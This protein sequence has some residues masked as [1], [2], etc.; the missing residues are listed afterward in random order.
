MR[1]LISVVF[2]TALQSVIDAFYFTNYFVFPPRHQQRHTSFSY[3]YRPTSS[4]HLTNSVVSS[5]E[6][7]PQNDIETKESRYYDR[8]SLD[9]HT[10]VSNIRHRLSRDLNDNDNPPA[11]F[12]SVDNSPSY[13]IDTCTSRSGE[14][15]LLSL[16]P[17]DDM[18]P[19]SF[20]DGDDLFMPISVLALRGL[21]LLGMQ[22]GNV[23]RDVLSS[24]PPS[25][26]TE[27]ILDNIRFE[28]NRRQKL[29]AIKNGH[30]KNNP[31]DLNKSDENYC[32]ASDIAALKSRVFARSSPCS[33]RSLS[34]SQLPHI[35]LA[36]A[37]LSELKQRRGPKGAHSLLVAIGVWKEHECLVML[38]S[39]VPVHFTEKEE[40]AAAEVIRSESVGSTHDPDSLLNIR[41]DLRRHKV[42]TID[43]AS[44]SEI[45]DGESLSGLYLPTFSLHFGK[46]L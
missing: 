35:D 33:E 13:F 37:L 41:R 21:L 31:K 40:Q 44:T 36:Y 28:R 14:A 11:V 45:D 38:R 24:S 8:N 30:D 32:H 22:F 2:L 43:S 12:P 42:Y 6:E 20:F 3:T 15:V 9:F 18:L 4:R 5:S 16:L 39:G 26:D 1:F 34:S 10:L 7:V 17:A 25:D 19:C 29:W 23:G 46:N 27:N